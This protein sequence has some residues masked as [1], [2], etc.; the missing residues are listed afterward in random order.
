MIYGQSTVIE[1]VFDEEKF[2]ELV[3]AGFRFSSEIRIYLCPLD[4][5]DLAQIERQL[6]FELQPLDTTRGTKYAPQPFLDLVHHNAKWASA[7]VRQQIRSTVRF[8]ATE[9]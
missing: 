8:A 2:V 6:I 1:T 4:S 5:N 7:V 9:A 3:R